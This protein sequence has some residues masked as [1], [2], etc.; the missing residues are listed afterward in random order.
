VFCVSMAYCLNGSPLVGVVHDPMRQETFTAISGKGAFLNERPISVS[1]ASTL[2]EALVGT[3]FPYDRRTSP[4][5]NLD[6]FQKVIMGCH[7]IRRAGAAALD[8]CSIASGRLDAFWE[9]KLKPWDLA[10][11]A[12]IIREAGGRV[13]SIVA[14]SS[15]AGVLLTD[16]DLFNGDLVATNGNLS[17]ELAAMLTIPQ[18]IVAVAGDLGL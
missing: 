1:S 14:D 5:N 10:A 6:N 17:E 3:G 4:K 9:L 7:G 8:L 12:L 16:L 15:G 18:E 11:G 2:S 13:D